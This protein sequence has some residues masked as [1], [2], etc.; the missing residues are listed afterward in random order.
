LF[1]KDKEMGLKMKRTLA[2]LPKEKNCLIP[3]SSSG[4]KRDL[5]ASALPFLCEDDSILVYFFLVRV[6]QSFAN[7]PNCIGI[8]QPKHFPCFSCVDIF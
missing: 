6:T 5:T 1:V 2:N 4:L 8:S 7:I 3:K